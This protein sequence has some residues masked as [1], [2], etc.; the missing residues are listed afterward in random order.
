MI[1][2][3]EQLKT[4]PDIGW[5]V[6]LNENTDFELE[7]LVSFSDNFELIY[8]LQ[9]PLSAVRRL[10]GTLHPPF[11]R[12]RMTFVMMMM[13]SGTPVYRPTSYFPC[14]TPAE[15]FPDS[16]NAVILSR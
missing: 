8:F 2:L 13:L 11:P 3:L 10:D 15:Y 14:V 12:Y 5:I 6:V 16:E 1:P 4:R 9:I 7:K